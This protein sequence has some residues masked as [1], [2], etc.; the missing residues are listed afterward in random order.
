MAK[1][2]RCNPEIPRQSLS[3]PLE[4]EQY[5]CMDSVT[6]SGEVVIH[7]CNAAEYIGI[8]GR[9]VIVFP[10]AE[11][12][13]EADAVFGEDKLKEYGPGKELKAIWDPTQEVQLFG[14]FDIQ[15]IDEIRLDMH[16]G[17]NISQLGRDIQI[18]DWFMTPHN[19]IIYEVVEAK[20]TNFLHLMYPVFTSIVGLPRLVSQEKGIG[21]TADHA[22]PITSG[23]FT[24]APKTAIDDLIDDIT[25]T[26]ADEIE[27][28][29][30]FGGW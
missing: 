11:Y 21:D 9:K 3:D 17:T 2:S 27:R 7:D 25:I 8:Y 28:K 14:R 29:G 12:D 18:G 24:E 30:I 5:F 4:K 19:C 20:K 13:I 10:I 26:D 6:T 1:D 16:T 23:Y 15:N 22:P